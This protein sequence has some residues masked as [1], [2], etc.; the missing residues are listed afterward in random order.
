[1]IEMNDKEYNKIRSEIINK[2]IDESDIEKWEKWGL[3]ERLEGEQKKECAICFEQ[4]ARYLLCKPDSERDE[5]FETVVFPII[6]RVLTGEGRKDGAE[7]I[8]SFNG[9]F[10]PKEI[11]DF[12]YNNIENVKSEVMRLGNEKG[13]KVEDLDFEA[14]WCALM[15]NK[16]IEKYKEQ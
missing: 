6:R 2:M 3:L 8:G 7:G 12:Y 11:E 9:K 14:E 4:M 16:L 1:M 15:S 13:I 10:Y 5:T